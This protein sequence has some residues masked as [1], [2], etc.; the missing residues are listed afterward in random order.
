MNPQ[1]LSLLIERAEAARDNE[2]STATAAQRLAL[3]SQQ[4]LGRLENFQDDF[5]R[6]APGVASQAIAVTTLEQRQQFHAAIDQAIDVQQQAC[7]Q[8]EQAHQ[9]AQAQLAAR[10]KRL[11]ALQSLNNRQANQ[12]LA[13]RIRQEQRESD[14]WAARSF[15][16]TAKGK[17]T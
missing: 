12:A 1:T 3:E 8:R 13:V 10:Q 2:R 5:L 11:L 15:A 17:N 16:A 6:R 7:V 9:L 4:T 14:A